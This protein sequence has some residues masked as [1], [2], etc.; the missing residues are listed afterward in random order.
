MATM[1]LP[2]SSKVMMPDMKNA[3]ENTLIE[4]VERIGPIITAH[5]EEAERERRL[6]K[7]VL[8]AM[9]EAGLFR[10]LVPRS[11]GG[12]EVA[13][14]TYARVVEAVSRHDSTAG[15]ALCNPG[16][17]AFG[18]F[19]LPDQGAE[20]IFGSDKEGI[21]SAAINPP[22]K[23]VAVEGGYRVTG[24]APFVSNCHEAS[25]YCAAATVMDGGEHRMKDDGK[26]ELIRVYVPIESCRIIDT[27]SV[28]G[29]RG[30]GSDDVEVDD[31][32]VP[33]HLAAPQV[34]GASP[35]RHYQGPLYRFSIIGIVAG[36]VGPVMLGI[37]RNAIDEVS[38]LAQGKTP[39][40]SRTLLREKSATQAKLARAEAAIRSARALLHQTLSEMW[41]VT[42]AQGTLSLEQK[43]D[44]LLASANTVA[45][46]V[47]AVELMYC[48][49]GTTGFYTSSPLERHFRDIQVL[50]QHGSVSEARFESVGQV[51]LGLE[52][53]FPALIS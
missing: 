13:P 31:V 2:V 9:V 39:L 51:Y 20:E 8:D 15:W 17:F 23:A 45:S 36:N 38:A 33:N 50:K 4:A 27:W 29:M 49:A 19:R 44:L 3:D 32:F 43:A 40:T 1:T 25:W 22:M 14:Q 28:M 12:L 46:S 47:E 35:G 24:R 18:C 52:P 11:L 7:P 42:L 21:I 26:P 10:M 6:S 41:G 16:A 53:D 34:P 37:A 5:R 30:T 48:V